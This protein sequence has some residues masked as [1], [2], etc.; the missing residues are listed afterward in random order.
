M[1]F[2]ELITAVRDEISEPSPG[3]VSDVEVKRW[4]NRAN[5]DLADAAGVESA[6]SQTIT[7]ANGT[8]SYSLNSD[9]GLVER[10]ELVDQ[11]D[12]TRYYALEPIDLAERID[13]KGTPRSYYVLAGLLYLNPMPDGVY[14]VRVWYYKVGATLTA[15]TDVP[16]IPARFHDLLTLFAVSQAKRKGD[17]PAYQTYL[18]DYVAGRAGMI[19]YLRQKS[20]GGRF[21]HVVDSD[22]R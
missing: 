4:L 13:S 19:E 20:Q 17:D 9:F 15:N 22:E 18:Q 6:A 3:F 11:T 8:E 16:I 10:V 2:S 14:T 7:T 1:M 12:S 5:Y 21:P